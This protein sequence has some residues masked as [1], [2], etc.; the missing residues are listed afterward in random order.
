MQRVGIGWGLAE[1]RG[2][3]APNLDLNIGRRCNLRCVFCVDGDATSAQRRW[4]PLEKAQRELRVGF[5][6]GCRSLALLGGEATVYP[7]LFPV[8]EHARD[9]GY[10]QISIVT[11]GTRLGDPRLLDRLIGS[12]VTRFAISIHSHRP[13]LEAWITGAAGAFERKVA[14]IRGVVAR[15]ADG[16][17]RG[18]VSLNPVL[19]SAN[20][21]HMLAMMWAFAG[22]GVN[23]I[24]FNL[25][26]PT[27]RAL[28]SRELTPPLRLAGHHA[29]RAIQENERR[30]RIRLTFSDLPLCAWPAEFL[31][32]RSLRRR[33]LGER[34]DRRTRAAVWSA[35]L[36]EDE[37]LERFC[38][39]EH[40][41]SA[42]KT[43]LE[44]CG[45]CRLEP[46][47]EGVWKL[48]LA[49]HGPGEISPAG[50]TE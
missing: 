42:L 41:Q 13:D 44:V 17:V 7:H 5:E 35:P 18:N 32:N 4:V 27:G 14:G 36:E 40:R 25:I 31:S 28:G 3:P 6:Q 46:A 16:R 30:L 1:G 29:W 8:L 21:P 43:K 19:C 15:L 50:A 9:L 2:E 48:Y 23:D 24:R 34:H 10:G 33:Y 49:I 26:H 39:V 20:I 22:L 12:G 38:W 37:K 47:C 45:R 11:N